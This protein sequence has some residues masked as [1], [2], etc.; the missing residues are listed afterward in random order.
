MIVQMV[1]DGPEHEVNW[2]SHHASELDALVALREF[3][4]AEDIWVHD[5]MRHARIA[6][7]DV[8]MEAIGDA[9]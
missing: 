1:V 3:L 4:Q 5:M 7:W 6:G 8:K 2:V 9:G